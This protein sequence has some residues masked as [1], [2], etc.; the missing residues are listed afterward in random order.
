M[1]SS[2]LPVRAR[3]IALFVAFAALL[4]VESWARLAEACHEPDQCACRG[5]EDADASH[6]ALRRVDCCATPCDGAT[7]PHA[8]ATPTGAHASS[9]AEAAVELAPAPTAAMRDDG[10]RSVVRTRGPPLR[11]FAVV[12]HWLL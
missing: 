11:R 3:L 1:L 8:A 5:E 9:L 10:T 7:A 4:P 6:A 12:E 2:P